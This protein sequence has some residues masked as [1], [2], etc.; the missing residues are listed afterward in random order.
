MSFTKH[1]NKIVYEKV[2]VVK[3]IDNSKVSLKKVW[4]LQIKFSEFDCLTGYP[5]LFLLFE[6]D[7]ISYLKLILFLCYLLLCYLVRNHIFQSANTDTAFILN[8][9]LSTKIYIFM[10]YLYRKNKFAVPNEKLG[11]ETIYDP[12]IFVL[13]HRFCVELFGIQTFIKHEPETLGNF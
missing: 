4:K 1:Q 13:C 7:S 11:C 9:Q 2:S 8:L 5:V 12:S 6:I 3:S 10:R